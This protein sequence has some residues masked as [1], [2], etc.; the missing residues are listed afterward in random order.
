MNDWELIERYVAWGDEQAFAE[1][2][3]R[4]LAFVH[5]S[6][7]RQVGP[8]LAPDVAQA[9]FLILARKA[10]SLNSRVVLSSWLFRTTRFVAAQTRRTEGRRMR[11]EH[12]LSLAESMTMSFPNPPVVEPLLAVQLERHLD[13][14]I[15]ALAESDRRYVLTRFFERRRFSDIARRFGVSEEAAKKR[16]GRALERMRLFLLARGVV[17]AAATLGGWLLA[18]RAEALPAGL[19]AAIGLSLGTVAEASGGAG[20]PGGLAAWVSRGIRRAQEWG[21][22]RGAI[23]GGALVGLGWVLLPWIQACYSGVGSGGPTGSPAIERGLESGSGQLVSERG[24]P[25]KDARW[26]VLGVVSDATGAEVP[27][28]RVAAGLRRNEEWRDLGFHRTETNGVCRLEIPEGPFQQ[29]IVHVSASNYVPAE[30]AGWEYE[31]RGGL[32]HATCRLVPGR[33]LRGVV[34]D[35]SGQGVPGARVSMGGDLPRATGRREGQQYRV[36]SITGEGGDYELTQVPGILGMSRPPSGT[37]TGVLTVNHPHYQEAARWLNHPTD[38]MT[39]QDFVLQPARWGYTLRGQVVDG[40]GVPVAGARVIG[41]GWEESITDALGIFEVAEAAARSPE[42]VLHFEVQ[43]R[44]YDRYEGQV[45]VLGHTLEPGLPADSDGVL[46]RGAESMLEL[47]HGT[48][49]HVLL[50]PIEP[51][52]AGEA[53][54]VRVRLQEPRPVRESTDR[55]PPRR[56]HLVGKVVDDVS[57]RPVPRFRVTVSVPGEVGSR[58]LGE[59]SDGAFDWEFES[60]VGDAFTVNLFADGYVPLG[61]GPLPSEQAQHWLVFRLL[62]SEVVRGWIEMPDGRSA[63]AA[64]LALLRPGLALGSEPGGAVEWVKV[65][66]PVVV[67][68]AQGAYAIE[69]TGDVEALAVLHPSGWAVFPPHFGN[70]SIVRLQAWASVEGQLEE[71]D[72]GGSGVSVS[73]SPDGAEGEGTWGAGLQTVEFRASR[74]PDAAGRFRFESVPEGIWR[75][76]VT[77][78]LGVERQSERV[79]TRAGRVVRVGVEPVVLGSDYRA[80]AR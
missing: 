67:A 44:G 49:D 55:L 2:V 75:V 26:L 79:T 47:E 16:V 78:G 18:P 51:G 50:A 69:R 70:G 72:A 40:D 17:V 7:R 34:R 24:T 54:H 25:R 35:A 30:L 9:V 76:R 52:V 8:G 22:R 3:G 64:R 14:A 58:F 48:H 21:I 20:F 5:A 53:I 39:H 77:D 68:D 29:W 43:A 65:S 74:I 73:I 13:D 12:E 23:W 19:A 41:S 42:G 31:L 45:R 32:V 6:A 4:Y 38:L 1:L 60:V 27:G 59:G 61:L 33:R 37:C 10:R 66:P 36:E 63:V 46:R 11:R 71:V 57:G 15:A 56:L 62:S 80:T 28:A